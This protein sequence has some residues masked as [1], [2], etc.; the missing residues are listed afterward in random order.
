MTLQSPII[1]IGTQRSGTTWMGNL[2]ARHP[3]LAYWEEPRHVWTWGHGYRPDD[4]LG[5]EDA[6][7]RITAHIRK[8]F[9]RFVRKHGKERLVEKTPSN[10][11]RL[12]FIRAIYPEARMVVVI[13]DGR[14]VIRSTGEQLDKGVPTSRMLRRAIE[15]APWEW[16]A[17]AGRSVATIGRRVMRRPL[18]F[19]GPRPRGW[20]EWVRDDP[21]DVVLAKQWAATIG[22][23]VADGRT[24]PSDYYME[25]RYEDFMREPREIMGRIV[26]FLALGD[27]QELIEYAARSVDPGRQDKW[28]E[29]LDSRTLDLIRPHMEPTL[30]HLGY[31]W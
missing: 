6:T 5:A 1:F 18:A 11:L 2:L 4:E 26:D 9:E 13:R 7:P 20:R 21:R 16:P 25:Y 30:T 12:P 10:C 24:M 15:T 14:S 28:R 8:T 23:A 3:R 17:Y 19:W 31:T 22:K 27:A 29:A